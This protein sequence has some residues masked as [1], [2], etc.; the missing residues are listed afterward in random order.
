LLGRGQIAPPGLPPGLAVLPLPAL[1]AAPGRDDPPPAL[2]AP[3]DLA[4]IIYTSGSTGQ[5]KGVMIAHRAA[6]NYLTWAAQV[7]LDGRPGDFPLFTSV[8]FDLTVTSLFVPLINGGRMIIY[9]DADAADLVGRVAAQDQADVIKLTPAHLAI[10]RENCP[11]A[12]RLKALIVGG[13][14]LKT[15]LAQDIWQ[16]LGGR[17]AIYN[18]YGPTE[19]TVGCMIHRYD[20][21]R[22]RRA[23][24]PIGAPAGNTGLY[25]LD[26]H[27]RPAPPGAAGDLYIAGEGLARGYLGRPAL[28]AER[29][30]PDPFRPGRRMYQSGDRARF[31][32]GGGLEYLGRGDQQI[33][34]H[35]MRIEPGEIEARL[36]EHPAVTEAAVI[37]RADDPGGARLVAYYTAAEPCPE[38]PELRAWLAQA[39]PR[40]MIPAALVPLARLPLTANG[41]LDRAALPAPPE[42]A[43]AQSQPARNDREALV[44]A[45]WAEVLGQ[46]QI[47]VADNFFELGGDSIKAVQIAARLGARGWRVAAGDVLRRQ[48]VAELAAGLIPA[49]P[50]SAAAAAAASPV[51]GEPPMAAWFFSGRPAAPEHYHQSLLLEAQSPLDPARLAGALAALGGRHPGLRLN[52]DPATGRLFV[53]PDRRGEDFALARVSATADADLAGLL[54]GYKTA[55]DLL[56]EPLFRAVLVESPGRVQRLLLVAHH[57]LVDLVS[58]GVLLEDLEKAYAALEQGRPPDLAPPGP[59]PAIWREALLRHY[60]SPAGL[61]ELPYWRAA[62]A[63][64]FSLPQE[65]T[66][67]AWTMADCATIVH[68]LD[69][70]TSARLAVWGSTSRQTTPADLVLAALAGALATWC[71]ADS[72]VIETEGHGR[73]AEAMADAPDI[74]RSLGWFTA[75]PPLAPRLDGL[76]PA[77]W[78]A[79]VQRQ[80]AALPNQGLGFLVLRHVLNR[81]ELANGPVRPAVRFNYLGAV[82]GLLGNPLLA[83]TPAETGPDSAP[84]NPMTCELEVMALLVQGRLRLRLTHH[85]QAQSPATIRG[86]AGAICA[87]LRAMLAA[88]AS[89]PAIRPAPAD[90]ASAGLDA[91][92]LDELF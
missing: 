40:A 17:V 39:L 18:E 64:D 58:W 46:G 72:M 1:L 7:Y 48:T 51:W 71:G 79:Q 53:N 89:H 74:G 45:V 67:A 44:C 47:G 14:D 68:E 85:R 12:N 76:D 43:E 92:D 25:V 69:A 52:C 2:A 8:A 6:L 54:A 65:T 87:H 90:F 66:P 5:P 61:A 20:P 4:Y 27:L 55:W 86:L 19:A 24:V 3:E 29:F 56:R 13:E 37:L 59:P 83:Y 49:T 80:A 77:A 31:L 60:Q 88:T 26:R 15:E 35:G 57:L 73:R 41:K 22:D 10:L 33:K 42:Q 81:P 36:K 78:P 84:V 16:R 82:E 70:E 50:A 91:A 34:L 63:V 9:G 75:M 23:S 28:T 32:P 38:P 62:L 30:L 11:P 21:Q